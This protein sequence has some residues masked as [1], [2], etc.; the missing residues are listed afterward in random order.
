M[1]DVRIW[2]EV[3]GH[4]TAIER[5][6]DVALDMCRT[7][8]LIG[9]RG[10]T[11]VIELPLAEAMRLLALGEQDANLAISQLPFPLQQR[12]RCIRSVKHDVINVDLCGGFLYPRENGEAENAELLKNL[13]LF[14]ARQKNPF[15]LIITFNL[16]DT[17]KDDY[18][19]FIAETLIA[20]DNIDI[21][22]DELREFYLGKGVR[23]EQPANLRRLRFCLPTFLQKI[24]Y[25]KFEVTSL[26]AWYYK[27]AF[28]H[29]ALFFQPRYGTSALGLT[30]PPIDEFRTLLRAELQLVKADPEGNVSIRELPAPVLE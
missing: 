21:K 22:T 4:I 8:Q 25:E 24:A 20:L 14:Q 18:D 19:Q 2:Q 10:R 1:L 29:T 30:W 12:I 16:R 11:A 28:Y 6:A 27:S 15:L 5:Y 13:V 3:L 17:G 9:V 26:G 7:A 23:A